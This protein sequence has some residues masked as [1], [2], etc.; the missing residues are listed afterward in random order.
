MYGVSIK[1]IFPVRGHS[2]CQNDRNF[3]IYGNQMKHIE[4][5]ETSDMY[6]RIINE[7]RKNPKPF[8]AFMAGHLVRNWSSALQPLFGNKSKAKGKIFGIQKCVILSYRLRSF[9]ASEVY[10][11][12]FQPYTL[13][14]VTNLS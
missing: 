12:V 9:A 6:I 8:E 13:G 10:S 14:P 11:E 4:T 3:G 1:H 2:F 5:I 7:S